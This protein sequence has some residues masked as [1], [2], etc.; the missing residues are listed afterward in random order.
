[1]YTKQILWR[2]L[3]S[4][5]DPGPDLEDQLVTGLLDPDPEDPLVI[6]L[7]DPDTDPC[8]FSKDITNVRKTTILHVF[9]EIY[10]FLCYYFNLNHASNCK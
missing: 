5:A 8:Y 10:K 4:V 2:L 6:G 7:L 3:S 1:M 9:L